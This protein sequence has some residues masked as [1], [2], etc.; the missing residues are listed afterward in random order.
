M[1]TKV[2][3]KCGRELPL[4]QFYK[5][6]QMGDGHLNKCIECTKN[7]EHER[8]LMKSQDEAWMEKERARGREKY[9]RL[10]YN[11][12]P[13]NLKTRKNANPIEGSTAA[14]LRRKGYDTKDKEAHHWNYNEPK[15]VFLLSRKAHRRIHQFI[16]VNYDDKFCYTIDGDKLDTVEKTTDYY[17]SVL[18]QFG[19]NED[20]RLIDYN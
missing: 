9:K 5:H 18:G 19:I 7:D 8:Y 10:N 3:F 11:D 2:C 13:W 6:K 17:K 1:E 4:D 20:L 14:S 15:Q 16:V 12:K